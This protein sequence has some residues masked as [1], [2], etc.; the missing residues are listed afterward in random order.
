MAA[1]NSYQRLWA[2]PLQTA[3]SVRDSKS[4]ADFKHTMHP[5][6]TI[7][8]HSA[9]I[10]NTQCTHFKLFKHTLHT[11][12]ASAD[13]PR[14]LFAIALHFGRGS[15]APRN[16]PQECE[17]HYCYHICPRHSL[18]ACPLAGELDGALVRL[19]ARV[20]EEGLVCKAVVD[21]AARK[22]NLST[23][24]KRGRSG[25]NVPSQDG[26]SCERAEHPV[27]KAEF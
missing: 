27:H 11:Q 14:V 12:N 3:P 18:D 6:Q 22:L 17:S 26:C 1:C 2:A 23:Q 9:Q 13:L 7:Q 21:Q 19:G 10:S 24:K 4:G 20:A 5:F 16:A 15:C 25:H 8:T